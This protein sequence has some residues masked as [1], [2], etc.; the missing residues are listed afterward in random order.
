MEIR[1]T[2]LQGLETVCGM[3]A[4][5]RA[6]MRENGNPG[7]WK[8][9]RPELK[10]I[11][12]DISDGTGYICIHYGDGS[13]NGS[14]ND[15]D[16]CDDR[17]DGRGGNDDDN[18]NGEIAAVFHYSVTD[19]PTYREIDGQW[20]NDKPYRVVHRIAR[21]KS[22]AGKGAAE[23]CLNRCF[24]KCGN[25]RIDTH[26]DNEPMQKLQDKLGYAY[27]GIIHMENGDERLAYRKE[28][29]DFRGHCF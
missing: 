16:A 2:S 1:K 15:G 22:S 7:Q 19:E 11:K 23:Y 10:E 5:A 6:F 20:L 24:S 12:Q 27:C 9:N 28:A 13:G 4:D 18:G 21:S 17:N 3:C 26:R 25:L 8:D 14:G 29:A